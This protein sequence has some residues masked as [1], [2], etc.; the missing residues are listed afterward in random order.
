MGLTAITL[1]LTCAFVVRNQR[2]LEAFEARRADD[3]RRAVLG[4]PPKT[5]RRRRRTLSDL[6][7][8]SPP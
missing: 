8:A 2:V 3:A 4:K 7:A 1:F 6:I 5:R